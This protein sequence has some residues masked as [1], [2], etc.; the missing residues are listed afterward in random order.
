MF[1]HVPV[2][3]PE[4]GLNARAVKL[5]C[6]SGPRARGD[7]R[8]G[9]NARPAG[10]RVHHRQSVRR[11]L[12]QH[13]GRERAL[14]HT[15]QSA[16]SGSPSRRVLQRIGH[17]RCKWGCRLRTGQRY[18]RLRSYSSHG[19][20]YLWHPAHAWPRQPSRRSP[21]AKTFDT[22]GWFAASAG[23]LRM[24]APVLL[25]GKSEPAPITHVIHAKDLVALVDPVVSAAFARFESRCSNILPSVTEGE[26]APEGLDE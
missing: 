24:I 6:P 4:A 15:R 19:E 9:D 12:L 5:R 11:I 23:L 1:Q 17:G 3:D 10:W 14:R 18:R 8:R 7:Q 25:R 22:V 20:R 16:H 21:L 26:A 13:P 2:L